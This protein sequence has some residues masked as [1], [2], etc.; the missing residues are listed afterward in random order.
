MDRKYQQRT[1]FL[2]DVVRVMLK[3]YLNVLITY[4]GLNQYLDEVTIIMLVVVLVTVELEFVCKISCTSDGR[5][6][7]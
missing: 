7:Q 5:I 3:I 4:S 6:V 1:G 2:E